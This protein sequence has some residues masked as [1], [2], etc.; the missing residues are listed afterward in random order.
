MQ[1]SFGKSFRLFILSIFSFFLFYKAEASNLHWAIKP[2][3]SL[4]S[5]VLNGKRVLIYSAEKGDTYYSIARKYKLEPKYLIQ[6][7][8]NPIALSKGQEVLVPR[9]NFTPSLAKGSNETVPSSELIV[10][11]GETLYSLAHAHGLTVD[12]LMAANSLHYNTL[13]PGQKIF[14]PAVSPVKEITPRPMASTV[15]V[16]PVHTKPNGSL[17]TIPASG[18]YTVGQGE[19]IYSI[20]FKYGVGVEEL[21]KLNQIQNN[22]IKIGQ[23]LKLRED[24]K[25][26]ETINSQPNTSLP[27][28]TEITRQGTGTIKPNTASSEIKIPKSE[29]HRSRNIPRAFKE[30]GMGIWIENNDLNQAKSVALHRIAPVGT[31]IKVTNPMTKR[32][33]FVKVV[34]SFPETEETKNAILVI[35]KSAASLIGAIDPHFRVE[36]SYAY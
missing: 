36:L 14:I 23:T 11:K 8:H 9:E 21:R 6:F 15:P 7:N 28:T 5:V 35:S 29:P 16:K 34:G 20:G 10:K 4:R 26:P 1:S 33:I 13:N 3:D 18:L 30:E 27:T 32:S 17:L 22:E 19:T 2:I 24:A 25:A 31:V 12:Q